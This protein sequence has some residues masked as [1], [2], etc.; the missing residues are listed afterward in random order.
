[1]AKKKVI[2]RVAI[3]ARVVLAVVFLFYGSVKLL[4]G[5][6]F[7]GDWVMDKKSVDGTSLVWAFYGYS[8]VYGRITGLFE[9]LPALLLF[10]KRTATL[11]ALG[12]FAVSLNITLMDFSYDYPMVKYMA[13]S[14]TLIAVFLIHYD[15]ETLL[16]AF[17]RKDK[18]GKSERDTTSGARLDDPSAARR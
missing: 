17:W 3:G 13:L 9:L 8:P 2:D 11:G 6:Y 7:Y 15:R 1:M 18:T 12:L 4:G 5:Q 16:T 14:Y 10:S